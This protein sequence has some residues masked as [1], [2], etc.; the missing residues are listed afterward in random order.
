[1]LAHLT[2]VSIRSLLLAFSAVV[3][4]GILWNRRSA[5]LQHAVWTAVVCG[6]LALFTFGQA[7]PRLPLP[8][9][10]PSDARKTGILSLIPAPLN[11]AWS[12]PPPGGTGDG[13]SA[14]RLPTTPRPVNW[15]DL[16]LYI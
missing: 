1:M 14:L 13:V 8:I 10:T 16:V 15:K 4:L 6:M 11:G 9:V 7:M 5:A 12:S 2:D 3:A